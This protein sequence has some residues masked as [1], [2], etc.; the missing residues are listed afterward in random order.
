M[1]LKILGGLVLVLLMALFA[2][3]CGGRG[4]EI[5]GPPP[6]GDGGGG[7][8][9]Y[10]GPAWT[11]TGPDADGWGTFTAVVLGTSCG[12]SPND[13]SQYYLG[14]I[15]SW[16]NPSSM[17]LG[18]KY[19][20]GGWLFNTYRIPPNTPDANIGFPTN[21][22]SCFGDIILTDAST[23]TGPKYHVP[24]SQHTRQDGGGG[25]GNNPIFPFTNTL[26]GYSTVNGQSPIAGGLLNGLTTIWAY[27]DV[28][29]GVW[30]GTEHNVP[31]AGY[32]PAHVVPSL[33]HLPGV[34]VDPVGTPVPGMTNVWQFQY[35]LPYGVQVRNNLPIR[36][37]NDSSGRVWG[38]GYILPSSIT[39]TGGDNGYGYYVRDDHTPQPNP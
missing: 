8:N 21:I 28:T 18:V 6:P 25:G 33:G 39:L 19:T 7:G 4:D 24:F 1:N 31:L 14:G 30:F 35:S 10:T 5:T 11:L 37:V 32:D 22:A 29:N 2:F 27:C 3:G 16:D 20:Q 17:P 38:Y 34:T 26:T 9:P 15:N 12:T 13:V 23:V 36:S